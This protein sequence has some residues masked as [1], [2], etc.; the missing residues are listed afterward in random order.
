MLRTTGGR[1]TNNVN[2]HT[3]ACVRVSHR[4]GT[5][6]S[7]PAPLTLLSASVQGSTSP[8]H[9]ASPSSFIC[10]GAAGLAR[11]LRGFNP[12]GV[13]PRLLV[14]LLLLLG[15]KACAAISDRSMDAWPSCNVNLHLILEINPNLP[16]SLL[17]LRAI[18]EGGPAPWIL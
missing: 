4:Y 1:N 10:C 13:C 6:P 18:T 9:Q 11:H 5:E 3:Y 14:L 2:L 15:V 12:A 17:L 16:D 8:S 7:R